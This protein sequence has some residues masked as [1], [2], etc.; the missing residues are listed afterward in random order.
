ML[1]LAK[2]IEKGGITNKPADLDKDRA[3]IRDA[4]DGISITGISGKYSLDAKTG[5]VVRPFMKAT[6]KDGKWNVDLMK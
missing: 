4:L 1:T 5:E 6:I 2:A 3:K